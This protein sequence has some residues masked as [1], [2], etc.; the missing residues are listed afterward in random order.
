MSSL[1]SASDP[2]SPAQDSRPLGISPL[3]LSL[4]ATAWFMIFL[5]QGSWALIVGWIAGGP[6]GSPLLA[7]QIAVLLGS[8][9]LLLLTLLRLPR[10]FKPAL[11]L[12]LVASAAADW[13]VRT[14]GVRIDAGMLRNVL[15]TDRAEAA[16]LLS[17]S[18]LWHLTLLGALPAVAVARTRLFWSGWL[19]NV[20]GMLVIV[21]ICVAVG[22]GA[23]FVDFKAIAPFL[24]EHG[25]ELRM[26]VTPLNLFVA[27]AGLVGDSPW[28]SPPRPFQRVAEHASLDPATREHPRSMT[29]LVV[30][31][32][33]RSMNFSLN[34]YERRT[35]PAL[36]TRD[37]VS[38]NAV[39]SCGT[40]TAVSL[41]CMFSNLGRDGFSAR[42]NRNR[43]NLLDIASR[44]G[45]EVLWLDNQSGSKG[46]ADR[47]RYRKLD[48]STPELAALT[49]ARFVGEFEVLAT[50]LEGRLL[51]VMHQMGSHG[52]EYFKRSRSIIKR[53]LP[54]CE[55]KRLEQCD[56]STI[57]NA[58]DNSILETD[59]MLAGLIDSASRLLPDV[60]VTLLYA[61]D[62][63]E[64]LG[65]NG[66][67][68]HGLPYAI[69]PLEQTSIPMI[70]WMNE[71][72][73]ALTGVS[74]E[75]ARLMR[76]KPLSHDN[77]FDTVLGLL[78]VRTDA[79][80]PALD[81]LGG[82]RAGHS[83]ARSPVIDPL[84]LQRAARRG[85]EVAL[86]V[87]SGSM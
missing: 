63:G 51:V 76:T 45:Y 49:D 87:P 56:E 23:V 38:F 44:A 64:S 41:P 46:I 58:Y 19:R 25:K 67:Y 80:R 4:L 34:G 20:G 3:T 68:L 48:D 78:R 77:W 12:L 1:H 33:A 84:A 82:C 15:Q 62:H 69:A 18:V 66:I 81:A 53:F 61:S 50:R 71:P 52:P 35:N 72:A 7:A 65:R 86:S 21:C 85:T 43:E 74:L 57:R 39:S 36:E 83:T 9:T 27:T 40:A 47:V 37:V 14:Y 70:L 8:I 28:L 31:E 13:F 73:Q 6:S 54:E 10:L 22:L 55:D 11:I 16:G 59:A 75:C 29:V 17:W 26:T 5:D 24:R 32:T 79:Y 30:G 42:R 60:P 2:R